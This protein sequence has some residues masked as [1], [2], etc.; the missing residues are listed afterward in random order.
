MVG[1]RL[2]CLGSIQHL[3]SR[4]GDGLVV[5]VK[6]RTPTPSE[7]AELV[8]KHAASGESKVLETD[9]SDER[10]TAED[11]E[12][13]CRAFGDAAL[14]QR[15]VKTHPTGYSLAAA[16][17]R[18]GFVRA[19]AFWSWCE[20]EARF[21]ALH[22]YLLQAF[23]GNA[24]DGEGGGEGEGVV[25]ME[26]Q[27]DFCRFKVRGGRRRL[28]EVFSRIEESKTERHIREYSVSQTTLEQIF[29]FFAA[30]QQEERGVARGMFKEVA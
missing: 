27:N 25:V 2:R 9:A 29:N 19:A 21:D 6:L 13:K 15:I 3:K 4:F 28:S 1:G 14:V 24:S 16:L 17:E 10:V 30:Q 22:A 5:D 26:R 12:D 8:I 18:D 11:L 23:G 20:E 7:V